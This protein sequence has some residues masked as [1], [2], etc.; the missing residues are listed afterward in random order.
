MWRFA[1]ISVEFMVRRQDALGELLQSGS[2]A[3][4][5][6]TKGLKKALQPTAPLPAAYGEATIWQGRGG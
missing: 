4:D 2:V 5:D 6:R 1:P 3:A